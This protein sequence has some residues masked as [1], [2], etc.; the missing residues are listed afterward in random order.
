[1]CPQCSTMQNSFTALKQ[2]LCASR[3]SPPPALSFNS[4]VTSP[5]C[6]LQIILTTELF[7]N[8]ENH[9]FG[10]Q[11]YVPDPALSA[12]HALS[13]LVLR[14]PQKCVFFSTFTDKTL[15]KLTTS[16]DS[17]NKWYSPDFNPAPKLMLSTRLACL[18]RISEVLFCREAFYFHF[19][20]Y[21]VYLK[22][23][24]TKRKIL[25]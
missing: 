5:L 10:A 22:D 25:I 21:L 1:M 8:N 19:K 6:Q 3:S 7:N 4:S 18:S 9:Y 20:T 13:H 23:M 14:Y 16:P 24:R 11:L 12:W 15:S 17:V 2:P